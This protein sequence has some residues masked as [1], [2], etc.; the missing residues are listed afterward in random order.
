MAA[1]DYTSR[2]YATIKAD[3]LARAGRIIPEWTDRDP[4][5]FGMVMVDLLAQMG[6]VLHYYV[7]RAAGESFLSTATQRES[8]LAFANLFDYSPSSRSSATSTLTLRNTG[9]TDVSLPQYQR[10]IARYDDV[11]YQCYA[12]EAVTLTAESDTPLTV[13]EGTI[14]NAPAETLTTASSGFASQR[15]RLI[16]KNVVKSSVVISVY[17]DGVNPIEYRRVFNF[18]DALQNE[19]VYTLYT[20]AEDNIEVVFGTAARGFIP[21]ANARIEAVYAFSSGASGNLAEDS[22]TEFYG[23]TPANVSILT[24]TD[25]SGGVNEESIESLR[26]SIP[27]SLSSQQRAVTA[28][29]YKSLAIGIEGVSKVAVDYDSA[30]HTVTIYPQVDRSSD[31]LTAIE[32]ID[33]PTDSVL[34]QVVATT[35]QEAIEEIIQPLAT[36]GITVDAATSIEWTPI[37]LT[38]TANLY[39][40]AVATQAQRLLDLTIDEFFK[41]ENVSFGQT[42]SLGSFYRALMSVYGVEYVNISVF[43][44]SGNT[45]LQ[46]TITVDEFKLPKK[47]T[48][49]SSV[50]GGI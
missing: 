38:V 22:I 41:F 18:S 1:F 16:N 20:T 37:D 31:Y 28:N 27:I 5:D 36:V 21:P 4:S 34:G 30:S 39:D 19:R 15:Y 8:V 49:I 3:M 14:V 10:F 23:A 29:D 13:A 44:T 33:P 48:I 2:D 6:D 26:N 35:T 7:D 9:T 12:P 50:V 25:F 32:Y 46:N 17:E 11:T 24:S 45:G 43:D 47:G 42:L 40:F